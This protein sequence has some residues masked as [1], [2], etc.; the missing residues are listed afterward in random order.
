M[1]LARVSRRFHESADAFLEQRVDRRHE[2]ERDQQRGRQTADDD[3]RQRHLQLA[4]FADAERHRD[5]TERGGD[6]CHQNRTQ[7]CAAGELDRFAQRQT[8]A[9]PQHVGVVHQQDAVADD[10]AG[11]HDD[12]DI[13]LHV[14]RRAGQL[15]CKHDANGRGRHREHDDER[16]AQRLVL[17]RHDG[18]DEDEREDQ[19]HP[20]LIERLGLFLDLG[21]EPDVEVLRHAELRQPR[22]DRLHRVAQ[23]GFGLG[24]DRDDALLILP[25]DLHR[26][27][28]ALDRHQV[29]RRHHLAL[30]RAHQ[31]V[32]HVADLLALVLA[33]ADDD[34]VLVARSRGYI[35]ACV[36]ATLVRIVFAMPVTVRPS[37]AAL[38]RSTCTASSGRA[39]VAADAR[40][41]DARRAVHQVL[42]VLREPP[43]VGEILAADFE[44]EPAAVVVAA[45]EEPVHLVVAAGRVGADDDAGHARTAAGA[46]PC[47]ICSLDRFRSS[48][49]VSISCMLP[50]W[51][52]PPPPPPC[53]AAEAAAAAA[54][55]SSI[56]LRARAAESSPRAAR[57]T[58]S[59]RS[60]RVPMR[61]LDVDVTWPSSACVENSV[62]IV[63]KMKTAATTDAT[64]DAR[65]TR[66]PVGQRE[67][68]QPA[69]AF[70]HRRRARAR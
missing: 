30:R 40:V 55:R 50:R 29:L 57:R 1:S 38:A 16:I 69:I 5:E 9:A 56:P 3:A 58:A 39:F 43:R 21:A 12:A 11:Q 23:G 42:G 19:H 4:A 49:G 25:L 61:E 18:V 47:A 70:V 35:A 22:L 64:L 24:A 66:R 46:A 68:N 34:R 26:T 20:Q 17:R 28:L 45:R 62:G 27:G 63:G 52:L 36:P 67:V 14:E 13:R 7:P 51:P 37:S 59:V 54:R 44:R 10:D 2:H 6:R 48:F 8:V 31:H 41:G 33:Q 15:Q 60:T 65:S 32:L 53:R